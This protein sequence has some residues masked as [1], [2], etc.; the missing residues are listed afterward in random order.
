M[1]AILVDGNEM[2]ATASRADGLDFRLVVS[3]SRERR[4]AT[5]QSDSPQ[6]EYPWRTANQV[7]TPRLRG[8]GQNALGYDSL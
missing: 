5:H 2:V 6:W 7:A 1:A 3:P 8:V 4:A